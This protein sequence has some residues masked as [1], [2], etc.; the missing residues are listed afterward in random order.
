MQMPQSNRS[1]IRTVM[2]LFDQP[3]SFRRMLTQRCSEVRFRFVTRLDAVDAALVED[4]PDA[5]FTIKHAGF[6]GEAHRR[7]AQHHSVRWVQVG[8]SGY[9][10]LLPL[11]PGGVVLT[12]GR[13][14][15]APFLAE[16]VVG[17]M[18]A[19]NGHFP[20]Y[21]RQQ[22]ARQWRP[23][24]FRPLV[25]RTLLI[26][27]L[28]EIGS[29]V[30]RRARALG[31]RV[32]A[33]RQRP[34]SDPSADEV[35]PA[36]ELMRLLPEADVVSLHVR[37]G[38]ATRHLIDASAL[39]TMRNDAVL[40]NTSRGPVVDEQALIAA[41]RDGR[42]AGA[43]LDVSETEPLPSDSPLWDLPNVMITPH[44]SD[45]VTDWPER[46]AALFADNLQ[47]WNAGQ[48]LI[49]EVAL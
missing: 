27:G 39:A 48:P 22:A 11:A 42:I 2:V 29:Q 37:L 17:A 46:F 18:L 26:V 38:D 47:R 19:L 34:M 36:S 30:G 44:A 23:I 20:T 41:L 9:D 15:L 8:G 16:T 1:A 13:G 5:V 3:D 14:V 24:A 7:A 4:H 32:I 43:Y 28:G 35:H 33:T 12:N 49:N 40:I 10:H 31:M 45:N 6:Q 21:L 25:G